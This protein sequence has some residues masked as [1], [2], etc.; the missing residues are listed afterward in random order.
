MADPRRHLNR[1]AAGARRE[2]G[3]RWMIGV[4][5]VLASVAGLHAQTA[6]NTPAVRF[7]VFA[8]KPVS[9]LAY[10]VRAGTPPQKLAFYPT[11]RSPR[12]EY[13]GPM[14]L[15]FLDAGSGAVVAEATIP[16][17]MRDALLLFTPL[18]AASAGGKASTLR[19][20]VAVLDDS[21]ARQASGTVAIINLSGLTLSGTVNKENVTLRAGLNP[22]IAAG[23]S[24]T[25][26]LR[27]IFNKREYQ[28]YGA[29]VPLAPKQRALVI[30]FPPFNKGSLEVQSRVLLDEPGSAPPR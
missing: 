15:R 20:Q 17:G 18:E 30:L 21:S 9:D 16:A 25:I 19:Y 27:T 14:P 8:A 10:V 29:T 12:Y 22:A 24:A 5:L 11:A 28:A 13:R 2:S 4:I 7:T 1:I 3:W 26:K 6:A 23:R